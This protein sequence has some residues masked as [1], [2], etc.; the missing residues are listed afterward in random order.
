VSSAAQLQRARRRPG[1]QRVQP[2][3]FGDELYRRH[4][5]VKRLFDPD[6]VLNPARS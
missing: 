2:E 3:I 4:A 5:A 1:P 6:E